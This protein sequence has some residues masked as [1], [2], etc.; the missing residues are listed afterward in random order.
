[1]IKLYTG[2]SGWTNASKGM[3][4][5][6][7]N[8]DERPLCGKSYRNGV[9]DIWEDDITKVTCQKCL[10]IYKRQNNNK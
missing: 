7:A 10:E 9:L 4:I 3:A 8:N 5:H 1:M 6:I 2:C